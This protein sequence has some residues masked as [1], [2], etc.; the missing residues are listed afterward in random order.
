MLGFIK[1]ETPA[2]NRVV[3]VKSGKITHS[4]KM[5]AERIQQ[6]TNYRGV[7]ESVFSCDSLL[8]CRAAAPPSCGGCTPAP[9]S[10][11]D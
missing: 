2:K 9:A 6:E 5:K 8:V 3:P 1:R 11:L 10:P 4:R 7:T